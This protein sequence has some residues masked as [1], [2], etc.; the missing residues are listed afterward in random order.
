MCQHLNIEF[1]IHSGQNVLITFFCVIMCSCSE[2]IT[3]RIVN[4]FVNSSLMN[5]LCY[6]GIQTNNILKEQNSNTDLK[7]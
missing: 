4:W 1:V 5:I 2:V 6:H 7:D 3:F